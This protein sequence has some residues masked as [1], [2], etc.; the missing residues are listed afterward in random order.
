[1]KQEFNI[2]SKM[3]GR[4]HPVF[5]IA[6]AGVN[7]NGKLEQAKKLIK[8]A[9]IAG[10]DC[11]KF[12]TFKAE[13][14]VTRNAPKAK[15]QLG[16]TDNAESQFDM[17]KA[18]ELNAQDHRQL[19]EDAQKLGLVFLSTPYNFEDVDLL[20]EIDVGAYK[21]ASGQIVELAFLRKIARLGKPIFLSTG[22]ANLN[23]IKTAVEVITK[24]DNDKVILLQCTTNYPSKAEDSNL[25]VIP[26]LQDEFSCIVGYSDHTIGEIA[27]IA[28]V[29]LGAKV[30]EKHFSLDKS[31][32]GP[33]HSS[34]LNP[35]ELKSLVEGIRNTEK[36]LG[37]SQKEPTE[38]EKENAA[39]MR[40]SLVAVRNISKGEIIRESD[41]TFKR[42]ATGLKPKYFDEL[43]GKRAR[44]DI[45]ADDLFQKDMIEWER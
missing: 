34:S 32:P 33:D 40:R 6:E 9:A 45:A 28:A 43:I 4:D 10:V 41:I 11:V 7:H 27:A 12:Q 19:K 14:V 1:M 44:K 39:G 5:I 8:E 23:E 22:M 26:R 21:V 36:L 37:I 17:L 35:Q 25:K 38:I 30:I 18:L 15:Y 3:I 29:A 13:R 20:E 16:T 31:L 2:G 42:P 24:E